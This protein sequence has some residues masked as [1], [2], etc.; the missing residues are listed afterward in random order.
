MV[1]KLK[2]LLSVNKILMAGL[3]Y[4]FFPTDFFFPRQQ[5]VTRES[6]NLQQNNLLVNTRT[7][8]DSEDAKQLTSNGNI[9]SLKA[10]SSSSLALAP[11]LKQNPSSNQWS[12]EMS[13]LGPLVRFN[14]PLLLLLGLW[15]T[16]DRL[17]GCKKIKASVKSYY[18]F[19]N[20]YR[21]IVRFRCLQ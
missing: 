8:E 13:S 1:Y 16:S 19:C 2:F 6:S 11:V 21:C 4:N 10:V 14:L 12:K 3:Q 15:Y 9:K 17:I 18:C 7:I 20:I 5:T